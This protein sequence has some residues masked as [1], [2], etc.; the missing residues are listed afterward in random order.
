MRDVDVDVLF[1]GSGC[2]DIL[3]PPLNRPNSPRHTLH[4]S[5]LM[6]VSKLQ[7]VLSHPRSSVVQKS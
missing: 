4:S 2:A 7:C 6:K 5:S 1:C 3:S